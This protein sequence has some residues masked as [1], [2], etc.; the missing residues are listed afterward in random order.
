MHSDKNEGKGGGIREAG[1]VEARGFQRGQ[2]R[3]EGAFSPHAPRWQ[4]P[5]SMLASSRRLR[6]SQS[7]HSAVLG[8]VCCCMLWVEISCLGAGAGCAASME[9]AS[10][11]ISMSSCSPSLLSSS[12]SPSSSCRRADRNHLLPIPLE[13]TTTEQRTEEAAEAT[14]RQTE[15]C[16]ERVGW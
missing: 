13:S 11:T 3:G 12:S 8:L 5:L 10:S 1:K 4:L 9:T 14:A 16:M 7:A 15:F 2:E 6:A